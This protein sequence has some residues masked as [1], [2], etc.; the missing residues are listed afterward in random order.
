[1]EYWENNIDKVFKKDRDKKIAYSIL[2]LMDKVDTIEIF[3]KKALYILLREI[4]GARTQ[5][6]TKVLNVMKGHYANLYRQWLINLQFARIIFL[7]ILVIFI[8]C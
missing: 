4:S 6:I 7:N 8:Y 3:N 1:M 5:H 2:E